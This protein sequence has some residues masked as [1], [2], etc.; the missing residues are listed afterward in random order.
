MSCLHYLT[1]TAITPW[2]GLHIDSGGA[3]RPAVI[4]PSVVLECVVRRATTSVVKTGDDY[5]R[6]G[7]QHSLSLR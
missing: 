6:G 7:T 5:G 4:L 1:P 3:I 2:S